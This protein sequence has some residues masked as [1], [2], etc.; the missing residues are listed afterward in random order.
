MLLKSTSGDI[1][2]N[3][4]T[5]GRGKALFVNLP[6]TYLVERT[7]GIFL[8]GMLKYFAKEV[9]GQPQLMSTPNGKGVLILNWHNDDGRAIGFLE[10]LQSAGI[11]DHGHQ[12][13]HF[14]AGPDVNV[15]GDKLGMDLNNNP[16]AQAMIQKLRN[17]G[18]S[19]GNHGG[20]IHNH[21][22]YKVTDDNMDDFIDFLDLN[23]D[24]VTRAN[25]GIA[26]REYSAPI[27]SQ[28]LWS[29]DWLKKNGVIAYYTVSNVGMAPT[30]LWMGRRRISDAWAFPVMTYGQIAS[31]EEASFKKMPLAEFD[32]WLQKL[33]RFIEQQRVM[34]LSYFHPVGAVLYLPAVNHYIDAFQACVDRNRCKFMSMSESA[35]FLTLRGQTTWSLQTH[36]KSEILSASHPNSL[37]NLS[38]TIPRNHY[39][40]VRVQSGN[41]TVETTPTAWYV[42]A[43]EGKSLTLELQ[44]RS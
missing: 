38:W 12:S 24:A 27:G 14:T 5:Y 36:N 43:A 10:T 2:S 22:G 17:Q 41:A 15:E 7:D 25:A 34:R 35:D 42:H 4:N 3:I 37:A 18:H 8:H 28:P 29:Y 26:P 39:T 11:F 1:V 21:F 6:L 9:V 30:R 23:N 16:A 40:Q 44:P 19:I 32:E 31:A 20:W 33:A 13:M